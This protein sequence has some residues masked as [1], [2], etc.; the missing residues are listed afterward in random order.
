MDSFLISDREFRDPAADSESRSSLP[1]IPKG[2]DLPSIIL[3]RLS[4]INIII[5]NDRLSGLFFLCRRHGVKC[6]SC[7]FLYDSVQ[8]HRLLRMN[9]FW[10]RERI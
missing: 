1:V 3:C 8:G 4:N 7:R 9:G 2:N 10:R 6:L 5:E